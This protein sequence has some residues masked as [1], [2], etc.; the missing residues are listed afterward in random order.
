MPSD[1]LEK[2][3]SFPNSAI[4]VPKTSQSKDESKVYL[5][6]EIILVNDDD[7]DEMLKNCDLQCMETTHSKTSTKTS[8]ATILNTPKLK[9]DSL[10]DLSNF[11]QCCLRNKPSMRISN[12]PNFST[13]THRIA[14]YF[15][16][17]VGQLTQSNLN[18]NQN[19]LLG[20]TT[21][22]TLSLDAY[23]CNE[24]LEILLGMTCLQA[25]DLFRKYKAS[26]KEP[27]DDKSFQIFE[28]TRKYCEHKIEKMCGVFHLRFD[29]DQ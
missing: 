16:T 14:G 18:W 19:C 17:L 6:Q 7:D 9:H 24:T 13:C 25:R 1:N 2:I 26:K 15:K 5:K 23:I 10:D 3:A 27:G 28:S 4:T 29:L 22:A 8:S 12:R 21:N 11:K 20:D